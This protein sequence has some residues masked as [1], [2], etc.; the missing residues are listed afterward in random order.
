MLNPASNVFSTKENRFA[1]G[2][3]DLASSSSDFFVH[4]GPIILTIE[5]WLIVPSA[6][7]LLVLR[8]RARIVQIAIA[9]PLFMFQL[10]KVRFP[11]CNVCE[12]FL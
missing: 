4:Q 10:C 2:R 1:L 8:G 11:L 6:V 12:I 7:V 3:D 5:A 9:L